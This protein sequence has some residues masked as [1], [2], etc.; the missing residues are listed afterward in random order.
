MII[1]WYGVTIA[2]I[3]LLILMAYWNS[4]RPRG[5]G[6]VTLTVPNYDTCINTTTKVCRGR[7]LSIRQYPIKNCLPLSQ[8]LCG[9]L[10]RIQDYENATNP[11]I[12]NIGP[13]L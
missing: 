10:R 9:S 3:T 1:F 5:S 4:S 8:H 11:G 7:A 12:V 6:V 2:F 13:Q